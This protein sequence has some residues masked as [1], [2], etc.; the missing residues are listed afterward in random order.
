MPLQRRLP[1]RGFKPIKR[2]EFQVVNVGNLGR[3]EG[4]EITPLT[5]REAGL[6]RSRTVPVKIL[7]QGDLKKALKVA[8][9]AFSQSAREK[10]EKA[11]GEVR[12]IA[13]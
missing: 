10:I 5:L 11:G 1:K 4:D 12:E 3:V 6:I 2:K 13:G 9:H 8:A 7:G